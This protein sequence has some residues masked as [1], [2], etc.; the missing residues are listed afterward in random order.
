MIWIFSLGSSIIKPLGKIE[1]C[2]HY[3]GK[4]VFDYSRTTIDSWILIVGYD[5]VSMVTDWG[6]LSHLGGIFYS[7]SRLIMLE[8]RVKGL[9]SLNITWEISSRLRFLLLITLNA[10]LD[11]E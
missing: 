7:S 4:V 2:L 3:L 11:R 1:W 8:F 6:D 9:E 10:W 5:G